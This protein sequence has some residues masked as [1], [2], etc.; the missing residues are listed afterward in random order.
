LKTQTRVP[1]TKAAEF[2]EL[3]KT[4]ETRIAKLAELNAETALE[5]PGLFDQ[6]DDGMAEL[7]DRGMNLSSELG[8]FETLS[9]QFK[10]KRALFLRR[11][12]GP[13]VLQQART[14]LQLKES[15]WWWYVDHSLAQES[16]QQ[17][18]RWL[19]ILGITAAVLLVIILLYQQFLAPDPTVRASYGYRQ[20]AENAI[21]NGDYETALQEVE[22]AITNTPDYP[23][24]Y[25]LRGLLQDKLEQPEA[26][27]QSFETARGI[28]TTDDQ[29]YNQ[30][31]AYYLMMGDAQSALADAQAALAVNPDSAYSYLYMAQAYELQG[32]KE[33][34]IESYEQADA[35]AQKT[36]NIQLQAIIRVSLSGAYQSI[37][38]PTTEAVGTPTP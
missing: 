14:G 20:N 32:E 8:Q 13:A 6:L 34:A 25:V 31:S 28:F 19:K 37:S 18:V 33:K 2:R 3:L 24:L 26:A 5:I 29:F 9:A 23:E 38:Y 11:I 16:K 10:K 4:L 12:G 17:T 35:I 27:S 22:N 36:E 1:P 21:L 15:H 7:Q 30:R